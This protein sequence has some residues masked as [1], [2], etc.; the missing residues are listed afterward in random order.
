MHWDWLKWFQFLKS[1]KSWHYWTYCHFCLMMQASISLWLLKPFPNRSTYRVHRDTNLY[2]NFE[3]HIWSFSWLFFAVNLGS[4]SF[5]FCRLS[6][7]SFIQVWWCQVYWVWTIFFQIFT[8]SHIDPVNYIH[9]LQQVVSLRYCQFS[10]GV[11]TKCIGYNYTICMEHTGSAC[12]TAP[13]HLSSY[14]NQYIRRETMT[15]S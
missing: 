13:I 1:W 9:V 6:A 11:S 5:S 10:Y 7:L 12:V 2:V 3:K 15:K 4:S 14:C 8:R